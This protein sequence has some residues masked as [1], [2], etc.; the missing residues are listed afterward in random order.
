MKARHVVLG[1]TG[2]IGKRLMERL[3]ETGENCISLN[4]VDYDLTSEFVSEELSE[5]YKEGDHLI[6]L[7]AL[8][9]YRGVGTEIFDLNLAIAKNIKNS[10]NDKVRHI[11]YLSTDGVYDRKI[12]YVTAD[13]APA[14]STDY[15]K[16]HLAR[17]IIFQ[18][19]CDRLAILRP[20]MV[21]GPDDPHNAYGPNRFIKTAILN[22]EIALFGKG[23]ELRDFIEL[24]E[25]V[26]LI[27]KVSNSEYLGTLNLVSGQS[28]TFHDLAKTIVNFLP[29]TEIRFLPRSEQI[30]HREYVEPEICKAFGYSPV[31]IKTHIGKYLRN[32]H[33]KI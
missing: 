14:P 28:V 17:E 6:V 25:L 4:S 26:T 29:K 3:Q 22:S 19:Y 13:T 12:R 5:Q 10:L 16:M 1:G 7:A 11:T 27:I 31:N 24:N 33:E 18:K 2:F 15:G 9:P 20:T 32:I 21:F 23:E 8:A 30:F